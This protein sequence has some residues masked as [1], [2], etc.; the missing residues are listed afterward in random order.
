MQVIF[1]PNPPATAG[2]TM[3]RVEQF[4][5][6]YTQAPW[7]KQ[8]QIL[9]I[10]LL[11]V[12]F[13]ALIASIY[14][15][16]SARSTAI[17]RDIQKKQYDMEQYKEEIAD[18]QGRVGA[19]YALDTM[20]ERARSLGFVDINPEEVLYLPVPSYTE[21][22]PVVLAPASQPQVIN[23]QSLPPEF[24]ESLFSWFQKSFNQTLFPLF[25]VQP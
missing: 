12:V 4:T 2:G 9:G 5:Q 10:F 1:Q 8:V 20:K 22:Q 7:R 6:A 3:E 18:L 16:V 25:K 17:G 19:M 11:V 13:A 23:A 14:L 15:N 24:T 21:R